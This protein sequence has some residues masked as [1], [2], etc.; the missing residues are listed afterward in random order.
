MIVT[1]YLQ[2]FKNQECNN[3]SET[4][5]L[6]HPAVTNDITLYLIDI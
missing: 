1:F 4:C 3:F 6:L 5:Y 2:I